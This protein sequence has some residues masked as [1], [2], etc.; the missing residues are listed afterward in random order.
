MTEEI[1]LKSCLK[2]QPHFVHQGNIWPTVKLNLE[3][4]NLE[5]NM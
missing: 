4:E 2:K 1:D 3:A 5:N